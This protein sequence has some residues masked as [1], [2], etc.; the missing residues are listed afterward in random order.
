MTKEE[1]ENNELPLASQLVKRLNELI[2]ENGDLVI[3]VDDPD[4]NWKMQFGLIVK[5]KVNDLPD[6]FEIKTNYYENPEG[7]LNYKEGIKPK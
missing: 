2:K 6:R 5:K 3:C 4:T 1:I 7:L